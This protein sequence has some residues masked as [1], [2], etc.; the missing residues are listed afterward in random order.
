MR[1]LLQPGRTVWLAM[2][3]AWL[4][5]A[6]G[7]LALRPAQQRAPRAARAVRAALARMGGSYVK[8]G[9]YLAIRRDLLPDAVCAELGELFA[10]VPPMS[11]RQL[12]QVLLDELGPAWT[13]ELPQFD[14]TPLAAASIAQVHR[15]RT[16]DGQWVAVKVQ[17]AGL[18][19]RLQADLDLLAA[20]ARLLDRIGALGAISARQLVQEV[21]EFTL[22]EADFRIEARTA[23]RMQ[24]D[25]IPGIA[26]PRV[27][28]ELTTA[29]VLVS[30]L[31]DG[32]TLLEICEAAE[33][34]DERRF[35]E[36]L[37]GIDA[38][39]LVRRLAHACFHQ[40]F[41]TGRFH[42][43]PHPANIMV[44]RDGALFLVDFGIFAELAPDLR[45]RF[46]SYVQHVARG[47][48]D[49]AFLRL[50]AL[51]RPGPDTDLRAYRRAALDLMARWYAASLERTPDVS[52]RLAARYQGDMFAVMR[53][54]R[55]AMPTDQLLFWRALAQVD[56][57]AQ[58][59]PLAFDLLAS[60]REFF[61]RTPPA[62]ADLLP[63]PFA[64][65]FGTALGGLGTRLRLRGADALG[66]DHIPLVS[67]LLDES[68]RDARDGNA[69]ARATA[70]ALL[71][72]AA[73]LP[74][75]VLGPGGAVLA[76]LGVAGAGLGALAI[77]SAR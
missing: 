49:D 24:A 27:R 13:Q 19:R 5:A 52:R 58:R 71:A 1:V 60:L 57:T 56:A 6:L 67:L 14:W 74:L 77:W 75:L 42:G 55:I 65:P 48:I 69:R 53:R 31:V 18:R 25:A 22:R 35:H 47:E 36:L 4:L 76:G 37:A 62:P 41:V 9:Q 3:A 68:A 64:L 16:A 66:A 26:I 32:H 30:E 21:A 11:T 29:R 12:E 23:E 17:R 70:L 59:L 10:R 54:C 8:L 73:S 38:Q 61:H 20:I 40:I 50:A 51:V 45:R 7:A 39:D 2:N 63:D 34:R 46:R 15:A 28:R 44:R 43:D 33:A 72:I